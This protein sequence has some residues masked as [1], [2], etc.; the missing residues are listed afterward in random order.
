MTAA[1]L[2]EP[3]RRDQKTTGVLKQDRSRLE[4]R[5]Y[6]DISLFVEAQSDD[7]GKEIASVVNSCKIFVDILEFMQ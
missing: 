6:P 2:A 3:E 7:Y 4:K 1:L 5:I